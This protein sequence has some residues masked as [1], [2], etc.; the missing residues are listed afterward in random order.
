MLERVNNS[1][2]APRHC[3]SAWW[4]DTG[5][6]A[7]MYLPVIQE[8]RVTYVPAGSYVTPPPTPRSHP[9]PTGG[10]YLMEYSGVG[11]I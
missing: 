7:Q 8:C 3:Y 9:P 1:P 2:S 4:T 10:R 6:L 11:E 5:F